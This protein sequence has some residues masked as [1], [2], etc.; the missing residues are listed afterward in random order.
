MISSGSAADVDGTLHIGDKIWKVNGQLVSS[1]TPGAIVDLLKAA[2]NPVEI[3][4]KR[5]APSN[6][7]S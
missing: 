6:K 5:V 1:C 3:I 7:S 4:V 2:S